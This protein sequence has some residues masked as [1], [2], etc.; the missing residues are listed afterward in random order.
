MREIVESF[1]RNNGAVR[2]N[3]ELSR[4]KYL[5]VMISKCT[6]AYTPISVFTQHYNDDVTQ[7]QQTN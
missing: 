4:L 7:Y 2:D 1:H 3:N 6:R 5:L